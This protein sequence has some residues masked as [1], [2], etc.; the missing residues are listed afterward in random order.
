MK[1]TTL[2]PEAATGRDYTKD[3]PHKM[4]LLDQ[5][6]PYDTAHIVLAIAAH[7]SAAAVQ[8]KKSEALKKYGDDRDVSTTATAHIEEIE[9]FIRHV[10]DQ[11]NDLSDGD[12]KE[13]LKQA[14]VKV[15]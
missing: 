9:D 15:S 7:A 10:I 12:F 11:L 4:V 13:A 2:L 3:I 14:K 6:G 1:I 8:G 5:T